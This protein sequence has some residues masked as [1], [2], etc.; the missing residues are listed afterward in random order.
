[1]VD[2]RWER[3]IDNGWG[4]SPIQRRERLKPWAIGV[5]SD[6]KGADSEH[7]VL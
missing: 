7:L 2:V 6:Q 5:L 3:N 1:M 4:S